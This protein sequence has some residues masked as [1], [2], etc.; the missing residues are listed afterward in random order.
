[1]V[2]E[3]DLLIPPRSIITSAITKGVPFSPRM[4]APIGTMFVA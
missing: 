1:M 2:T 4:L 3:F